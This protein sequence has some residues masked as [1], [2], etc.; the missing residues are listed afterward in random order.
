MG[1]FA[2]ICLWF[3]LGY[4]FFGSIDKIEEIDLFQKKI[5]SYGEWIIAAFSAN[6]EEPHVV[7][8]FTP[9]GNSEE[10]LPKHF[11]PRQRV[12]IPAPTTKIDVPKEMLDRIRRRIKADMRVS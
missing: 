9:D 10:L 12:F 4:D 11:D 5:S 2:A 7:R 1:A 3:N 6:S 8:L